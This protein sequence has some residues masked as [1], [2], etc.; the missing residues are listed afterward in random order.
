M[1]LSQRVEFCQQL[2]YF[3]G[4]LFLVLEPLKNS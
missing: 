1:N 4:K 3:F 2:V